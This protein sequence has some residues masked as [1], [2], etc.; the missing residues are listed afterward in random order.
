LRTCPYVTSV[1]RSFSPTF[2]PYT[3]IRHV[4]NKYIQ[5]I[6]RTHLLNNGPTS[7][8]FI[9]YT[10]DCASTHSLCNHRP[11]L[12]EVRFPLLT[13]HQGADEGGRR[14]IDTDVLLPYFY[15]TLFI[16]V[17]SSF[18]LETM[19][20]TLP[21]HRRS[22][23]YTACYNATPFTSPH[24]RYLT[25]H[26][27]EVVLLFA[28]AFG[29]YDP[30]LKF[31]DQQERI[32]HLVLYGPPPPLYFYQISL[33]RQSLL[34]YSQKCVLDKS[35]VNMRHHHKRHSSDDD[36]K[37]VISKS[38]NS[39]SPSSKPIVF[40]NIPCPSCTSRCNSICDICKFFGYHHPS[41][42]CTWAA[43]RASRLGQ[44]RVPVYNQAII[45]D[46]SSDDKQKMDQEDE[47]ITKEFEGDDKSQSTYSD[48]SKLQPFL[49]DDEEDKSSSHST[50]KS[51]TPS[52]KKPT[53]ADYVEN[54]GEEHAIVWRTYT[55]WKFAHFK[56]AK[57]EKT[58]TLRPLYLEEIE[59]FEFAKKYYQ[60]L[61]P[62]REGKHPY[63][64][65]PAKWKTRLLDLVVPTYQNEIDA[66]VE[67]VSS[68]KICSKSER[69]NWNDVLAPLHHGSLERVLWSIAFLKS[70]NGVA[71]KV[72][73]GHFRELIRQNPHLPIRI[74][75]DL[76]AIAAM[77]RQTSKWV[78]N[79]FVIAN[80]FRY[81]EHKWNCVPSEDFCKWLEFYEIGPKTGALIFHAA[82]G[83]METL[84]VDSHVWFAFR[85]WGWTN[86]LSPTECSWQARSW[87]DPS[88]FIKT[89]D[90]IGSL[91]QTLANYK[92][93]KEILR[94]AR[95][96]LPSHVLELLVKLIPK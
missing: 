5:C 52:R 56:G 75:E 42:H 58:G 9:S 48:S 15:S 7:Q 23:L 47:K 12:W 40:P 59:Y 78:K 45:I 28:F 86:A 67:F 30:R 90:V 21:I 24:R 72:S 6:Y 26:L 32:I 20:P 11:K 91:R 64:S 62:L 92:N 87:M 68:S 19:P 41:P 74:H 95:K 2:L 80:I 49:S 71:D 83:R 10:K 53:F 96:Q 54:F 31:Q 79:T 77:L 37:S 73:C 17:H 70:T 22:T 1:I 43:T 50:H 51:L 89:N 34:I 63:I 93:R 76:H 66:L 84:P 39:P 18:L 38:G 44:S 88:Y 29:A 27:V 85:H 55:N 46:F 35:L 33:V 81:I 16:H 60:H 4:Y 13:H 14:A 25:D 61:P 82:F 65:P 57:K 69:S 3:Q 8:S 94:H 36:R